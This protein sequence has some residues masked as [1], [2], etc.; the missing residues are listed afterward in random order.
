MMPYVSSIED[1]PD[2][3]P[4]EYFAPSEEISI[5]F[6]LGSFVDEDLIVMMSVSLVR[7]HEQITNSVYDIRFGIFTQHAYKSYM[8]SPVNFSYNCSWQYVAKPQRPLVMNLVC[9]SIKSL[10]EFKTPDILT[11][12]T[13]HMDLPERAMRKYFLIGA[14]LQEVGYKLS[15]RFTDADGRTWWQYARSPCF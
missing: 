2:Y 8:V 13:F 3:T 5:E 11:M 4:V 15:D 1:D 14:C 9:N 10:L 6:M 7:D 12:H